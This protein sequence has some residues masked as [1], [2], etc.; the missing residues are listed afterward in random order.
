MHSVTWRDFDIFRQF[1]WGRCVGRVASTQPGP[2]SARSEVLFPSFH[3]WSTRIHPLALWP[4]SLAPP[5]YT[6]SLFSQHTPLF[7]SSHVRTTS[8]CFPALSSGSLARTVVRPLLLL[9]PILSS[10][11][12]PHIH[13]DVLINSASSNVFSCAFFTAH[14][15]VLCIV[16]GL[17]TRW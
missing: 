9:L 12:T 2:A 1:T 3:P 4:S 5:F 10:V 13:L 6:P 11:A 17:T 8:A 15:S 16:A 14:V 7:F